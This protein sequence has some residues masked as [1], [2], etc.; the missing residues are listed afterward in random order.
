MHT[1][2]ALTTNTKAGRLFWHMHERQGRWMGGWDLASYLRTTCLSTHIAEIRQLLR[3]DPHLF[4]P[5]SMFHVEHEQRGR[6]HFYRVV[7]RV[8]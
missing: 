7:R 6:D 8:T 2:R 4:G 5:D 3:E 1:A